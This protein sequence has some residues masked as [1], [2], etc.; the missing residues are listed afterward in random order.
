M[1]HWGAGTEM[2]TSTRK[3]TWMSG[4]WTRPPS[5]QVLRPQGAPLPCLPNCLA[6]AVVMAEGCASGCH[7][8]E[9]LP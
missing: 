3:P 5:R 7:Q 6:E 8:W 1:A 2:F 4:S 9:S